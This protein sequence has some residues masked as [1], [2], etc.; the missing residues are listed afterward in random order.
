M[1]KL[2]Y[3]IRIKGR[4]LFEGRHA[5]F[6]QPLLFYWNN[7]QLGR[8]PYSFRSCKARFFIEE[9]RPKKQRIACL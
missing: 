1:Q 3:N 4:R 5:A 6:K 2:K 7:N 8:Y 9:E